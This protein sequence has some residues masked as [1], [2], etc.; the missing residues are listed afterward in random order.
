MRKSETEKLIK[1]ALGPEE[2]R[3]LWREKLPSEDNIKVIDYDNII[4]SSNIDD[5]FNGDDKLIIFYP[6]YQG[7]Y[8][9]G[10]YCTLI[11]GKNDTIFL[12]LMEVFPMSIKNDLV[13]IRGKTY[14]KKKKTA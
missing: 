4:N 8:L 7:E 6:N 1:Q 11:R 14:T 12:I 10:H 5:L 13:G 9:F 3:E 2:L